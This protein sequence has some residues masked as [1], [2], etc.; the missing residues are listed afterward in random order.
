MEMVRRRN[1]FT[2]Q[3]KY[4]VIIA[5]KLTFFVHLPE[6][7]FMT[8]EFDRLKSF[9]N[10]EKHGIDFDE[11]QFLW[12]D[13]ARIVVPA[14]TLNEIRYLMVARFNGVYW[15]V[16]YTT[17]GDTIRIISVRKSR[18]NEKEIYQR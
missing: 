7:A 2:K 11:A 3:R 5:H 10:K 4:C 13:P 6:N 14:R 8:F 17:R 16:I 1:K 12:L 9:S 18:Q 15:S